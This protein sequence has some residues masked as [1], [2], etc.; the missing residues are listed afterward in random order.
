MAFYKLGCI[1]RYDFDRITDFAKKRFAE[2]MP[3]AAL[4]RGARTM[5]EKEEA[6]I[7]SNMEITPL[8]VRNIHFACKHA[9][10]CP[11]AAHCESVLRRLLNVQLH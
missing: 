7:I 9:E 5:R 6:K 3:T 10:N 8:Q 1:G 2:G 4:V 11:A